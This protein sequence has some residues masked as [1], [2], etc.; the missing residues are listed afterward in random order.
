MYEWRGVWTAYE[1]VT[2]LAEL[3][4]RKRAERRQM[5]QVSVAVSVIKSQV[6]L[7]LAQAQ[8]PANVGQKE[9]WEIAI[10]FIHHKRQ[11]GQARQAADRCAEVAGVIYHDVL[12]LQSAKLQQALQGQ[13]NVAHDTGVS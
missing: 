12:Q 5:L 13:E 7:K 4:R 9:S 8:K 11:L 6:K 2:W 10:G 1:R 3:K